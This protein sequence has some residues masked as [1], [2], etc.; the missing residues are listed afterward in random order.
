[1]KHICGLPALSLVVLMGCGQKA[2]EQQ[3]NQPESNPPTQPPVKPKVE[4][5]ETTQ[6]PG[7][8]TVKK[9]HDEGRYA[10]A[11]RVYTAELATEEAKPAP[12]CSYPT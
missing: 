6:T 12:S 9:A 4:P 1:M 11:A 3:A 10:D 7:M 2:P 5:T 8:K